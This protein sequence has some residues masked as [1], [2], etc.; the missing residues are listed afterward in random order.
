[1]EKEELPNPKTINRAKDLAFF[2]D[3]VLSEEVLKSEAKL[4]AYIK[5][6][7]GHY[8]INISEE[9]L[10]EAADKAKLFPEP[11]E[12]LRKKSN[13]YGYWLIIKAAFLPALLFAVLAWYFL[14]TPIDNWVWNLG[15]YNHVILEFFP[16]AQTWINISIEYREKMIILFACFTVL[17]V[18]AIFYMFL[19]VFKNWKI[20]MVEY[21]PSKRHTCNNNV[22]RIFGG[23]TV[24]LMLVLF[25]LISYLGGSETFLKS[26]SFDR[27][28]YSDYRKWNTI[29]GFIFNLSLSL[30]SSSI[31]L[32]F[33]FM[34]ISSGIFCKKINKFKL[35]LNNK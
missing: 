29:F 12:V 17:L 16:R 18:F 4:Q 1:M 31:G 11:I 21:V 22:V 33:I 3:E 25:P 14:T 32:F 2:S 23:I 20:L 34:T 15:Q 9:E 30:F 26:V 8:L 24:A 19:L 7:S 10:I 6:H 27:S 35:H 13:R 5:R 28:I